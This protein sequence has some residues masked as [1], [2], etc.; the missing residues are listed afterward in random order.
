VRETLRFFAPHPGDTYITNH[1]AFG[2]S[3]LP[4][5]TL[6]TPVFDDAHELLGYI[7]NR[8][9]HAEIGGIT[10][11]SMPASATRLIE[12][13]TV[14]KPQHLINEGVSCFDEIEKLFTSGPF[15]T[16]NLGDNL[17]DLHA[18][19]AAN[20]E[21]AKRLLGLAGGNPDL[22]RKMMAGILDDSARVMR[23][24]IERIDDCE[25]EE[26]LDDGS[27]IQVKLS[28]INQPPST[29]RIDFTGTSPTHPG[30]LNA[31][32]AIVQSAVLYVL[33][34]LL[35]K[36]L[37]LNEGL[38]KP[39]EI[40]LPPCLLNPPFTGDAASDPAVVGGNVEVS[41]RLV[42]T[43]IK[44]LRLQ[45]C[46]QGTMNNLLFGNE[47]FGYYETIAGGSGAG[48]GY[49]GASALHTHMTNTA[50]TDPEII[51][52]RYPV[53][54][55]E[56]SIRRG[57]G[58]K[59]KWSGGDGVVREFEFLEPLTVSLLTQHRASGPFGIAGGGPGMPGRQVLIHGDGRSTDLPSSV[60]VIAAPGD[61][62]RIETPGG[63]GCGR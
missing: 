47:R 33:R 9:H 19:L 22:V 51:E 55:R 11:G 15:P 39:I 52:Q 48:D 12:E 2:G 43:L 24:Q 41:Q 54:L 58:G 31:T 4:D 34:L 53:L 46:S 1:P 63:G 62:L 49:D 50:I 5:I 60:A 23:Q 56:F 38:M 36:D 25:A 42:D 57:S 27:T 17:A 10:P 3:H 16:R 35:Q 32:Q 18:Q 59:G 8:A 6:I 20:L 44:A 26:H 29:L 45:A 13:G 28:T 7:A 21:G 30:N 40:I 37:P 14:I 61:R